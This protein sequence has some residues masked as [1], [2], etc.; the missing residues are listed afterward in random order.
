M[1]KQI[2]IY[3]CFYYISAFLTSISINY[4]IYLV[5]IQR[6]CPKQQLYCPETLN[7]N[8]LFITNYIL[9]DN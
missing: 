3:F 4:S 2:Y 7:L 8:T 6:P 5:N 1:S 9:L